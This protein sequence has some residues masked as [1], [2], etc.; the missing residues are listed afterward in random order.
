MRRFWSGSGTSPDTTPRSSALTTVST[1]LEHLV[2]DED[3]D[4]ARKRAEEI[5]A[6]ERERNR[7]AAEEED[8]RRNRGA[9]KDGGK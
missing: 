7:R 9:E 8:K 3:K 2:A 5:L 1:K 4:D 6:E